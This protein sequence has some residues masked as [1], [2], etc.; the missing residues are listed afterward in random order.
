M[1]SSSNIL[2]NDHSDP[3]NKKTCKKDNENTSEHMPSEQKY[4][5]SWHFSDDMLKPYNPSVSYL[6]MFMHKIYAKG[7]RSDVSD[8]F[9]KSILS[10]LIKSE[11]RE[12]A[13]RT[14]KGKYKVI[15][16]RNG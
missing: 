15:V 5:V 1:K 10:H 8:H 9:R 2:K 12:D 4:I 6:N 3:V 16:S 11:K 13:K 7:K 14:R